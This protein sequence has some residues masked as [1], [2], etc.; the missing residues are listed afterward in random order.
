MAIE[1]TNL[2]K[3]EKKKKFTK[4]KMEKTSLSCGEERQI[5]NKGR[6]E[7]WLEEKEN[8][9]DQFIGKSEVGGEIKKNVK[10]RRILVEDKPDLKSNENHTFL[11]ENHVLKYEAKP[12]LRCEHHVLKS[13]N[14]VLK[15]GTFK[16][17]TFKSDFFKNLML[18]NGF[19][20]SK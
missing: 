5:I 15:N 3:L 6:H 16:N 20:Q 17:V 11:N 7:E 9:T 12:D 10:K 1:Y 13:E 14:H 2:V 19:N 8:T 18:E 4:K